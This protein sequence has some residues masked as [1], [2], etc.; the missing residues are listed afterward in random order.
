MFKITFPVADQAQARAYINRIEGEI[1]IWANVQN[2]SEGAWW[3]SHGKE[4]VI[5]VSTPERLVKVTQ[6]LYKSEYI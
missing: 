4:V 5:G 6:E 1:L 3:T 2:E